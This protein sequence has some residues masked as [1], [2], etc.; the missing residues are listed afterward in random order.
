MTTTEQRVRDLGELRAETQS[1]RAN[2]IA[3]DATVGHLV[4][5]RDRLQAVIAQSQSDLVVI[6]ADLDVA[7]VEQAAAE[8]VEAQATRCVDSVEQTHLEAVGITGVGHA[9]RLQRA[10]ARG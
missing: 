9:I 1:A 5:E 10:A 7:E 2:R 8:R 4:H 6:Q 3:S